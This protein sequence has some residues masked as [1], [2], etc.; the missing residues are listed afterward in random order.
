MRI[1]ALFYSRFSA[2]QKLSSTLVD[3]N[4]YDNYYPVD[5][6]TEQSPIKFNLPCSHIKEALCLPSPPNECLTACP[7]N[8]QLPIKITGDPNALQF[9]R[10]ILHPPTQ[11]DIVITST[12]LLILLL[13]PFY[14]HHQHSFSLTKQNNSLLYRWFSL[15]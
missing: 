3:N 15:K 14:D 9:T 11:D 5:K 6:V 1:P 2:S 8:W 7:P 12:Q 13:E 10:T 4:N